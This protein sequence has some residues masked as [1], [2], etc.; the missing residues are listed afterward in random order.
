LDEVDSI[1]SSRGTGDD[2]EGGSSGGGGVG[3]RVLSTLLNEMNGIEH[4]SGVYVVGATNRL[5][6]I[7]DALRRPGRFDELVHITLPDLQSRAAILHHHCRN[8]P[9][10]RTSSTTP[11]DW[12]ALARATNG[13]AGKSSHQLQ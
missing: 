8:L 4:R 10:D 1:G 13:M 5:N 3:A 12:M 7:D 11:I 9:I 6:A 2:D